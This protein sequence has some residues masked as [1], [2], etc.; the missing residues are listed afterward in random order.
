MYGRRFSDAE[1]YMENMLRS[2]WILGCPIQGGSAEAPTEDP[3]QGCFEKVHDGH[4][5]CHIIKLSFQEMS[6]ILRLSHYHL[7]TLG[8][9]KIKQQ[10]DIQYIHIMH[11]ISCQNLRLVGSSA[12]TILDEVNGRGSNMFLICLNYYCMWCPIGIT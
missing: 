11:R 6:G 2:Q 9:S 4:G 10:M 8:T 7:S 3:A 5:I 12:P 1:I